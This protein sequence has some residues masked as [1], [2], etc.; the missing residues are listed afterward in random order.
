[1]RLCKPLCQGLVPNL[2]GPPGCQHSS[3]ASC[4]AENWDPPRACSLPAPAPP[5]TWP[6]SCLCSLEDSLVHSCRLSC[7]LC[8]LRGQVLEQSRAQSLLHPEA[9]HIPEERVCPLQCGCFKFSRIKIQKG[10]GPLL[11][12]KALFV[13]CSSREPSQGRGVKVLP[14][15]IIS[16]A[17]SS[18]TSYP[19]CVHTHTCTYAQ[20]HVWGLQ[21][22]PCTYTHTLLKHFYSPMC[23]YTLNA[24]L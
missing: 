9:E 2:A 10:P 15:G 11:R 16:A 23:V 6:P 12:V 13:C 21:T 7:S 1:M 5:P 19:R 20:T 4:R 24:S 14:R 22:Y 8:G 3:W 17:L 18:V